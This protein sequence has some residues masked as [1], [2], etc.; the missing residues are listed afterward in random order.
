[1]TFTGNVTHNGV[2]SLDPANPAFAGL[3]D[4]SGSFLL[5][6]KFSVEMKGTSNAIGGTMVMDKL[7]IGGTAGAK[8]KGTVITL[9]EA[10][11]DSVDLTGTA[12]IIISSTGTTNYP[13]G[14]SFGTHFAPLS[15]T[16]QELP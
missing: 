13:A 3:K 11:T 1:M 7:S 10:A 16:Y 5:A 2:E 12:D 4:L 9:G 6:P 8:V 14:V 15:D